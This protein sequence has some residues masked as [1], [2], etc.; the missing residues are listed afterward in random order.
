MSERLGETR[1][2]FHEQISISSAATGLTNAYSFEDCDQITFVC[3]LGT[4]SAAVT[5]LAPTF[6]VR[7]SGDLSLS[8]STTVGGATAVCGPTTANQVTNARSILITFGT[9]ATG[10]QTVTL[11]GYTM[12]YTTATA[13][14][15]STIAT[16]LFF[17]STVGSTA[18]EGQELAGN[19]FS[20]VVNNSTLSYWMTAST[21]STATVRLVPKDTAST[22]ITAASTVFTAYGITSEKSHSVIDVRAADLNSTSKYVG[23]HIST[24]AT[25]VTCGVTVIK[26]GL[27]HAPP[28]LSAQAYKKST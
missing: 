1:Q 22:G 13:S 2:I 20:S 11:N 8:T 16:A 6:T 23:I 21:P 7:Q 9:A 27:R 17:G 4:A 18:A 28:Y 26:S 10:A 3:G 24:V 5:G 19:S 25:A 15:G 12:T 14:F